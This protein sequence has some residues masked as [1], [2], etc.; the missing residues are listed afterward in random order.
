MKGLVLKRIGPFAFRMYRLA[1]LTSV[2][3]DV[4]MRAIPCPISADELRH[5]YSEEKLT[6]EEIVQRLGEGTTL[7]RVR[8]WRARFGIET[9]RRTDRHDV[10]PI[11]GRLRSLLVGS[12]LGD[13]RL[14][15]TL[16]GARFM[17]NH[18]D[19]QKEYLA[20][21]VA[22]WGSWASTK[23][24][25]VVWRKSEGDFHGWRFHT[26]THP[27]LLEWH[28][29]FY[30]TAGPKRLDRHVVPLVDAFA[31]AVWFMDD[32]S[33]GWW[34]H[35]TFGM[36]LVSQGIAMSAFH[37]L[38][39]QPRWIVRKGDTGDFIFEGEDQAHRFVSLIQPYIHESMQYKLTFGFQGPHYQ[40]RALVQEQR[41][42]ELAD[43]G[44]PIAQ[45]G[46]ELGV[47]HQTVSRYL[48]KLDIPHP[49]KIGRPVV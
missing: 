4:P 46:A 40:V 8:S 3:Y 19:A 10:P 13:G 42:R 12:M 24:K 48:K 11:E 33:S 31:L 45:I 27:S 29:L 20:W 6:D 17:E 36:D 7:K 44:V 41:L 34:P 15:R 26:V 38:G 39:L 25:P 2:T 32:G 14:S 37:A 28:A 5:L 22:E 47:S 1:V 18:C 35:I 30:D 23:M 9:L 21:K 43:R 49:R 16:N